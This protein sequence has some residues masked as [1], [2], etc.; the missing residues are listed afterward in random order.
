VN[1]PEDL[2]TITADPQLLETVLVNVLENAVKYSPEGS[3][4]RVGGEHAGKQVCIAIGD[5]GIGIPAADLPHV[6]DSFYRVRREDR[7]RPGTGLGLAIAR[8]MIEAMGGTITAQ[9]PRP[10]APRDGA[11]GTIVTICLPVAA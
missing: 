4:I 9:S 3:P 6:F 11:P 1:V 10:D 2:P 8:G 7:T 5:E